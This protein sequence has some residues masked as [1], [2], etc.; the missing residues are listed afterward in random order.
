[1]RHLPAPVRVVLG[2]ALT[3]VIAV[4][5]VLPPILHFI[6][7]PVAPAIG[8]FIAGKQLK[9]NDREAAFMGVLLALAAG[10]PAFI[11]MDRLIA[12]DT[13][14]LVA[15]IAGAIWTGGLATVAA[16]FA[17]SDEETVPDTPAHSPD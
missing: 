9:L 14:A 8:G 15:A 17:G 10:V 16:W 13:F 12:N 5:A 4:L 1:M 6:T 3:L 11:V 2:A 7:G